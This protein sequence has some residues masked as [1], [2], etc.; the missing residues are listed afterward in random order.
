MVAASGVVVVNRR[1]GP[2]CSCPSTSWAAATIRAL[3]ITRPRVI[4]VLHQVL[5]GT[6]LIEH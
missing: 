4:P 2:W 1:G 3:F 5:G 6:A